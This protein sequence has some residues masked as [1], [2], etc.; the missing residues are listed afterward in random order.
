MQRTIATRSSDAVYRG[1]KFKFQVA[2]ADHD[3]P[4]GYLR[5]LPAVGATWRVLM[6]GV[7]DTVVTIPNT[8][9][10][11]SN[12]ALHQLTITVTKTNSALLLAGG[13]PKVVLIYSAADDEQTFETNGKFTILTRSIE[14]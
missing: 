9:I 4:L 12:D 2:L 6:R 10:T 7:N 3:N 14:G 13:T 1:D 8:D 11:F 5:F